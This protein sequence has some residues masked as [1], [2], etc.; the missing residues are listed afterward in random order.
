M[1]PPVAL[2]LRAGPRETAIV[3]GAAI[4]LVVVSGVADGTLDTGSWR[5]ALRSSWPAAGGRGL[6]ARARRA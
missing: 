3:A 1:L 2:A 4:A 6:A 5:V